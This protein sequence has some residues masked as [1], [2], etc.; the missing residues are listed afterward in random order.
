MLYYIKKYPISLAIILTVVY[1]SFFKPASIQLSEVFNFDKVAHL[2][3]YFGMSGM[4]WL[5]FIRSH[6]KENA[7]LWRAWVGALLC[8][9]LFSGGIELLQEYA[10]TYRSGDW[11]DFAA[12]AI[13]SSLASIVGYLL[14]KRKKY[15]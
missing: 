15:K 8:P 13:G 1:L 9:V 11:W 5:E 10:T 2:C 3:M 4:L 7:P 12:N 14:L 6:K